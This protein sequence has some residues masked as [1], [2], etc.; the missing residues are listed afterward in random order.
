MPADRLL[1]H[2]HGRGERQAQGD[3]RGGRK[4]WP[5]AA[6]DRRR[7]CRHQLRRDVDRGR[8]RRRSP[9]CS[10]RQCRPKPPSDCRASRAARASSRQP[11]FHENRSETEMMRFLRRLADK[12]LA[13]DRTMIPL[14]SCTMK[15]NAAAE[16]M[17][18]SWPSVAN[19]HPFAPAA[20]SAGYRAMIDDLEALAR[21]D[22]RLRRRLAAAQCRQPGRIC[23]T[24]R[25][26][27]LS[28]VARRRQ[29]QRL[30]DPL[31]RAWHQS[32]ERS[33][34]RHARRRRALHRG[35]RHRRRR[36]QGEG[37][38]ARG[39]PRRADDHLSLDA[40]RLRGRRARHLRPCIHEHG[41][42]VYLDGANLNALV[43]W[44]GP[45]TSAPTSAT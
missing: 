1:R 19:L 36:S 10:A 21:R 9:R 38:R 23:R 28:R 27:P 34:G 3:R 14:G 2:G 43:G 35:R 26:P 24:A 5:A 4:G 16:M 11:V 13:L 18:V 25:H 29:P 17:P 41:G 12:D 31:L 42:Q 37:R 40:W 6:R 45:A 8:P 32:G 20:H 30:P 33:D 7:S 39:Q 15:L 22:H 44:R